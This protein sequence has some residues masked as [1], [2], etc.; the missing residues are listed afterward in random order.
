MRYFFLATVFFK[1]IS[2]F[3][4]FTYIKIRMTTNFDASIFI[5]N[6]NLES[7]SL[8]LIVFGFQKATLVCDVRACYEVWVIL[9]RAYGLLGELHTIDSVLDD[10]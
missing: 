10:K 2:F 9:G 8:S 3:K 6:F 4:C 1:L 7:T 5:N